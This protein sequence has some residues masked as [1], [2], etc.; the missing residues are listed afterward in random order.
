MTKHIAGLVSISFRPYSVNEIVKATKENGLYCIEWGSDVHAPCND[1]ERLLEI[2]RLQEEYGIYCSSYGTYF[3]LGAD[4]ISGLEGYINA[5]KILGTDI[6][7]LWCGNKN[8]NEYTDEEKEYL[9]GQAKMAA[10]LAE[11]HNVYVCME[12]HNNTYTET[13][14]GALELMKTVNSDFFR[15]YWQPNQKYLFEENI[16]YAKEISQ[17]VK[18]VHVFNWSGGEKH[19]LYE[20]VHVWKQYLACFNKSINFLLEFM[21]DDRIESLK[22]ERAA[23]FEILKN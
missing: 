22:K 16:R 14:D 12:C 18:C 5:A 15:M 11:K 7:R 19:P 8:R 17:Y 13:L 6:L 10:E 21:P 3:R 20:A 23:L 1:I 2:V 4:D 9:F